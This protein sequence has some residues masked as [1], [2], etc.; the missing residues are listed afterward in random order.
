MYSFSFC[1]QTNWFWIL[2]VILKNIVSTYLLCNLREKKKKNTRHEI[3]VESL[4]SGSA[5]MMRILRSE[6]RVKLANKLLR[7]NSPGLLSGSTLT[8]AM[9]TGPFLSPC[10]PLAGGAG[11]FTG[12]AD[13]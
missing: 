6:S 13:E 5:M 3:R 9:S 1:F 10:V 4:T 11:G 12:E 8:G 2:S 7:T